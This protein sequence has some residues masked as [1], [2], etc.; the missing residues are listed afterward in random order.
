MVCLVLLLMVT[1]CGAGDAEE[2]EPDGPIRVVTT[3]PDYA[4]LTGLT[5]INPLPDLRVE[6]A[7]LAANPL[8]ITA[9]VRQLQASPYVG[10]V[11]ILGSQEQSLEGFSAHSFTLNVA[12][13]APPDSLVRFA[14]V[15]AEE[16]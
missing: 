12:Y 14:P 7:G 10:E 15:T 16:L 13:A 4:W 8:A 2:R 9:F 1:A 6:V 5:E 11:R 3:L